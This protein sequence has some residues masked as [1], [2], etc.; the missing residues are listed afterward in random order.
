MSLTICSANVDWAAGHDREYLRWLTDQA[1]VLLLQEAKNITVGN[2]I[3]GYWRSLQDTSSPDTAGTCIAINTRTVALNG[4]HGYTI[5]SR[6]IFGIQRFRMLNRWIAYARI[7]DI[8][9]GGHCMA[10]SAHFPPGRFRLL[11]PGFERNLRGRMRG[12][13]VVIGTDANQPVEQLADRLGLEHYCR[14]RSIVGV[15]TDPAIHVS[16]DRVLDYGKHIGA[17]DHPAV[18]VTVTLPHPKENKR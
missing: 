8:E 13:K 9:A 11:Q 1:D 12:R 15:M 3:P 2:M 16:N 18:F 17:T 6:P 7:R 5:G 14:P 10:V 4:P